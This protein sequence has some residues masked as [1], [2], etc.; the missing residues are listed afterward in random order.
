MGNRGREH[1]QK[2]FSLEAFVNTLEKILLQLMKDPSSFS[3]SNPLLW[4]SLAT[5]LILYYV[6]QFLFWT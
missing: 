3:L 5:T 1:V 4:L 2:L 6:C